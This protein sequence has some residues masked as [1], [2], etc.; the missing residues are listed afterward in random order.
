MTMKGA[1]LSFYKAGEEGDGAAR[2]GGVI[3]GDGIRATKPI[4]MENRSGFTLLQN[5]RPRRPSVKPTSPPPGS[6]S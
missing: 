5:Y 3:W 2:A 6:Q 4:E 1:V